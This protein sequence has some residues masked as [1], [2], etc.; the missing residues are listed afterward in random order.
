MRVVFLNMN[1]EIGHVDY[2]GSRVTAA[3][4]QLET[5]LRE[6]VYDPQGKRIDIKV[7]PDKWMRLLPLQYRSPYFCA[8][9]KDKKLV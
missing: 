3:P 7:N 6:P 8:V 5:V 4:A 9:L 1:H 2:D